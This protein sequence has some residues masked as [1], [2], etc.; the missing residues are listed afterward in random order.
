MDIRKAWVKKKA[1]EGRFTLPQ[2]HTK[3]QPKV[4]LDLTT[5]KS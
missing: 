1:R 4:A 3:R 5:C 2:D